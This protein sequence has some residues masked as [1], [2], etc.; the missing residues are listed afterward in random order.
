MMT[1]LVKVV[2]DST[3]YA[4]NPMD[5]EFDSLELV[6]IDSGMADLL[7]AYRQIRA[8][9]LPNSTPPAITIQSLALW[10]HDTRTITKDSVGD[11]RQV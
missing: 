11:S 1:D 5:L 2:F 8:Y 9:D 3:Y 7:D 10:I 4:M 6:M